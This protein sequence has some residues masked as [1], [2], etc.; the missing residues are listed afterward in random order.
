MAVYDRKMV[1]ELVSVSVSNMQGLL[2]LIDTT[3]DII[4]NSSPGHRILSR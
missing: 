3:K 4:K 2:I 1:T